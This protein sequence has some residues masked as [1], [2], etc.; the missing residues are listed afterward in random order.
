MQPKKVYTGDVHFNDFN[1]NITSSSP[2]R[3]WNMDQYI[4]IQYTC[5]YTQRA[6]N[7]QLTPGQE[8]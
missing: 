1:F 8:K 4:R 6:I 5:T 3:N 7:R 2:S